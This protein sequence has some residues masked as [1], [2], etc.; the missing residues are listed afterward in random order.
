MKLP[1]FGED[2]LTKLARRMKK[3]DETAAAALYDELVGKVFGFCMNRV[4]ER[5]AAEDLAQEVFLKVVD[6]IASFDEKKGTFSPWFWRIVRNTVTDHYRSRRE[7]SLEDVMGAQ[8]EFVSETG[9]PMRA[10]EVRLAKQELFGFLSTLSGDEQEIFRLRFIS[11][12]SY[13]EMAEALQKSEGSLR[14]AVSR[15]R[16]KLRQHVREA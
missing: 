9:S 11:E 13:E 5:G 1:F 4:G 16:N 7:V 12:L 6:N 10:A 14:V 2:T 8:G 3:G 15:L